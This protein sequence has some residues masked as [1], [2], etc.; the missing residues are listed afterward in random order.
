MKTLN[1]WVTMA[2]SIG[3]LFSSMGYSQ[4]HRFQVAPVD[5]FFVPDSKV[6]VGAVDFSSGCRNAD[7][8]YKPGCHETISVE[9]WTVLDGKLCG[10]RGR[11]PG[12]MVAFSVKTNQ[13]TGDKYGATTVRAFAIPLTTITCQAGYKLTYPLSVSV[14]YNGDQSTLFNCES[15]DSCTWR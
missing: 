15:A 8:P 4:S 6:I 7:E 12:T 1:P 14:S 10:D 13:P 5:V 11:D 9:R 3:A 2:A